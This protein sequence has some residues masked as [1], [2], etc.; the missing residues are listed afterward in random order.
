MIIYNN[1]TIFT[2]KITNMNS[3]TV[4]TSTKAHKLLNIVC[5]F[6]GEKKHE[7]MERV[8]EKEFSQIKAEKKDRA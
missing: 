7:L 5:A 1:Y 4:R 6:T 8:L 2:N 3:I